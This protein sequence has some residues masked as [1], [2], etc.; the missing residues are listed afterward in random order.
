MRILHV[1]PSYYPAVRYGGPIRS[2]HGLC[3]ALAGRGHD[4]HVYTT[5]A[6]GGGVSDV[7]IGRPVDMQ[8]V[9]VHYFPVGA[10]RRLYRSP[11]MKRRLAATAKDFDAI[12]LHSVFLWPTFAAAR[13]SQAA[14]TPYVIS[15][16]G[17]LVEHL[18][19]R[20]SRWLKSAWIRLIERRSLAQAAAIHV[21]AELESAELRSLGLA[22][23][24]IRCIP[25]G[26]EFPQEP[27]PRHAGA[28]A[29]IA[30][31]YALFLSRVNWKKG[32]DRLI[33]A[34]RRVPDLRLVIAGPDENGY[35]RKLE[36]QVAS[37]ELRDRVHFIGEV[38]DEDKWSLYSDAMFV[39][40]PSY[41]ENFGNVVAEA[42]AMGCP[43][44]VTPEVG[45]AAAVAAA[46]AGIVTNNHPVTRA[47]AR[48]RL[49]R[50]PELRRSMGLRGASAARRLFSW[51][52]IAAAMETVYREAINAPRSSQEPA[53]AAP[54]SPPVSRSR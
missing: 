45:I 49:A 35:R 7:P 42:M 38:G 4:V 12:H 22:L 41:S 30:T 3:V 50:S 16:R 13:A 25:N 39:V 8:G 29:G 1:V 52:P 44:V 51:E 21:T 32:L 37:C 53:R 54:P 48:R 43:V 33:E 6:D 9:Q 36:T 11:A 34:W 17:M 2:V 15:P 23:P 31:P 20:K 14:G 26:L 24:P 28:Y 19:R 10:P 40:L 46:G 18:I 47:A 27:R 5:N